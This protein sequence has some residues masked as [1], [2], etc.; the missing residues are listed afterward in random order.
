MKHCIKQAWVA[1]LLMPVLFSCATY[2]SKMSA[3][4][5][6]VSASHYRH[7]DHMLERNG[8]L[9]HPRNSLLYYME[10]GQMLHLQGLYDSSNLFLNLADGYIENKHKSLGNAITSLM[11]NPM[12]VPYLGEDFERFMV[13]YYK[14]LNYLY[15]GK[16]DDALVEARRISLSTQTQEDKFK[17]GANRYTKDAFALNVQ[18]MIYEAAGMINDAFI[19]YRNAADVYL[20]EPNNSYYGVVMPMQLKQDVLRTAALM[21]FNDQL[22]FYGKKFN[23]TYKTRDSSNAGGELVVFFERGMAP[24]KTEQNFILAQSGDG[25]GVFVFNGPYGTFDIP[26]DVS[27]ANSSAASLKNFRTI[28]VAIPIYEPRSYNNVQ[29][30]ITADGAAYSSE[31]AEDINTI[32]P[33]VLKE[34]IVKEVSNALLRQAFKLGMEKGASEATKAAVKNNSK[35]KDEGKKERNAE[36]AALVTGLVVNMFNTATE[37]ADTRNWQSLPAYIQY[38]RVPLKKGTNDI[39]L[40]LGNAEKI[41]HIEGKTGL[42]LYNW[43][44]PDNNITVAP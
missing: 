22:D 9:Q 6:Q 39:R 11:L 30:T 27:S 43:R 26:F 17:P 4:Y 19:A 36:A 18:G 44:V 25:N 15:L 28:R 34:R 14:A 33:A 16:T 8:Y 32:A 23:T 40:Q 37:K 41:I 24:A 13:H 5:N 12:T 3:Y 31:L 10:R 2:N 7:A 20:K 35:E 42:Q 1:W 29:G 38:V 21:G